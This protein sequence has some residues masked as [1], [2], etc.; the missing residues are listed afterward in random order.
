MGVMWVGRHVVNIHPDKRNPVNSTIINS[1]PKLNLK[2]ICNSTGNNP[3]G[4]T[5]RDQ[6]ASDYLRLNPLVLAGFPWG[7]HAGERSGLPG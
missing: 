2:I 6:A 1:S 4:Q 7:D 5:C 3:F